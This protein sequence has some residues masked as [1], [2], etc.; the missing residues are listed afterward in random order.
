[1]NKP[2]GV[3]IIPS[4]IPKSHSRSYLVAKCRGSNKEVIGNPKKKI[5]LW[6][7]NNMK[8]VEASKIHPNLGHGGINN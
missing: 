7:N 2:L 3:S 5:V 4:K 6:V 1:M 8:L